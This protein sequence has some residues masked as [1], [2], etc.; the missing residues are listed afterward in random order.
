MANVIEESK[1]NRATCRTCRQKIDKGVLR[2][3]EETPN[4]FDAEAGASYMWH[5]LLCAAQKKGALL[6]PVLDAYAGEVP[7][8]A[9]LEA[10]IA[11]PPKGGAGAGPKL[12]FPYA[13]RASTG[14]SKCMQCDEPIAK[15]EWRIAVEREVDT[16]TF[17]RSGPGYLHPRCARQ[18]TG[19]EELLTKVKLNSAGLSEADAAE[20]GTLLV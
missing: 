6:K 14:R 12:S 7:N 11:A 15:G 17:S 4:Q 2:F 19:D 3:G 1:S 9:E 20:L 13:E 10:A 18:N 5:H 16:G 8:R